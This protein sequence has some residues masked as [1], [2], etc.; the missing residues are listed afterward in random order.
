MIRSVFT[1]PSVEFIG[2]TTIEIVADLMD[3]N[4]EPLDTTGQEVSFVII[5]YINQ[6]SSEPVVSYSTSDTIPKISRSVGDDGVLNRMTV[7]LESVATDDLFGKFIYQFMVGE[8]ESDPVSY[9]QGAMLIFRNAN[10]DTDLLDFD[11]PTSYDDL[12]F[13]TNAEIDEII[14]E[15]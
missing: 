9:N 3:E 15:E 6:G 7:H 14:S 11:D 1:L 13:L 2:G 10:A 12:V 8:D 5:S 4:N